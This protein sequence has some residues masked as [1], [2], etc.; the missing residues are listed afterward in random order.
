MRTKLLL[1]I[2]ITS[3]F[4]ASGNMSAYAETSKKQA[5]V[6]TQL[7][8][9]FFSETNKRL[10]DKNLTPNQI[11]SIQS[12]KSKVEKYITTQ[13][14]EGEALS[15]NMN[16]AI[17]EDPDAMTAANELAAKMHELRVE[18]SKYLNNALKALE[19]I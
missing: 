4:I 17:F 19:K 13:K 9:K 5:Q 10:Q 2:L 3:C 14:E 16:I 18:K 15:S 7:E 1:T 11:K 8:K 6:N 12:I